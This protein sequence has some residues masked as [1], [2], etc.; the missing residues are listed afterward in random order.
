MQ[1]SEEAKQN[2]H[3]R[4]SLVAISQ[5]CKGVSLPAD[6]APK[7][8]KPSSLIALTGDFQH[9]EETGIHHATAFAA[10][11]ELC[12]GGRELCAPSNSALR[13]NQSSQ[14]SFHYFHSSVV[15]P[16]V[17]HIIPELQRGQSSYDIDHTDSSLF[18][19]TSDWYT[20]FGDIDYLWSVVPTA[21]SLTETVKTAVLDSYTDS[22]LPTIL[23]PRFKP[24]AP[25]TALALWVPNI[26]A[27]LAKRFTEETPSDLAPGGDKNKD[28]VKQNIGLLLK[29]DFIT[30]TWPFKGSKPSDEFSEQSHVQKTRRKVGGVTNHRT[31]VK[32]FRRGDSDHKLDSGSSSPSKEDSKTMDRKLSWRGPWRKSTRIK[33][34]EA[35]ENDTKPQDNNDAD[36]VD[37]KIY[38]ST[39]ALSRRRPLS[40]DFDSER[41]SSAELP[42]S[43]DSPAFLDDTDESM[44]FFN[45]SDDGTSYTCTVSPIRSLITP[46][47]AS[48]QSFSEQSYSTCPETSSVLTP[49]IP[50]YSID[51]DSEDEEE[52]YNESFRMETEHIDCECIKYSRDEHDDFPH[53]K[54]LED[55]PYTEH[56]EAN[57]QTTTSN[58]HEH[59]Q[60]QD[61]ESPREKDE[62]KRVGSKGKGKFKLKRVPSLRSNRQRRLTD[63][64]RV[65]PNS[66]KEDDNVSSEDPIQQDMKEKIEYMRV[67]SQ[68]NANISAKLYIRI[69]D[70]VHLCKLQT[71]LLLC[72][73]RAFFTCT[74]GIQVRW[75]KTFH[76]KIYQLLQRSDTKIKFSCPNDDFMESENTV[77]LLLSHD[78]SV[79]LRDRQSSLLSSIADIL[80]IKTDHLLVLKLEQ[81]TSPSPPKKSKKKTK[82]LRN[83]EESSSC[84]DTQAEWFLPIFL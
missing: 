34:V 79:L 38:D 31:K 62:L 68:E 7:L 81:K 20:S 36:A 83:M 55:N 30:G 48:E 80:Q 49:V 14:N 70:K 63:A 75:V 58:H 19:A 27:S 60:N 43:P 1:S 74:E 37:L 61:V 8:E 51:S 54:I 10:A 11:D 35:S 50:A 52:L 59:S 13:L 32:H 57:T 82:Q 66:H 84:L 23:Q 72:A 65:P 53:L 40:Q 2:K 22:S 76:S 64:G 18:S 71:H 17:C 29:K 9:D 47:N 12:A 21:Q 45:Y 6:L 46:D 44:V 26:M 3:S 67:A 15:S 56:K 33:Y 77:C 69:P 28:I 78:A 41:S 73:M 16:S 5:H 42:L 25:G 24:K 4:I 39:P